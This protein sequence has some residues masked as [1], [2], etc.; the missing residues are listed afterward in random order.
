[1]SLRLRSDSGLRALIAPLAEKHKLPG[2]VVKELLDDALASI[3]KQVSDSGRLQL[4]GFGVFRRKDTPALQ[5]RN[6]RTG[7]PVTVPARSRIEFTEE[8]PSRV[9]KP[10]SPADQSTR[11]TETFGEQAR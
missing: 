8:G 7:E 11:V 6:P 1:M 2:E 3:R 10:S 9:R 5:R 4:R